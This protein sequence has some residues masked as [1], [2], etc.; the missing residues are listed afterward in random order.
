MQPAGAGPDNNAVEAYREFDRHIRLMREENLAYLDAAKAAGRR[1]FG[2]GAPVKGNTLLNY[3]GVGTERIE[4]LVEKNVLRR[5]LYSPG[6][7][8]P[9]V[10]EDELAER[11]DVYYVLAWNF[12]EEI[13]AN[14]RALIDQGVEFYFPVDP[15]G[16]L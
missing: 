6:M 9:V 8:I 15:E 1:V 2:F 11:P 5:G 4:L 14:N 13:L 16:S 10:L 12:K 7:H 3:F